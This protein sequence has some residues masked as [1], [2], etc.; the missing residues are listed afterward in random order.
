MNTEFASFTEFA[1]A[2]ENMV[3]CP[4]CSEDHCFQL[5]NSN[6][7]DL[8]DENPNNRCKARTLLDIECAEGRQLDIN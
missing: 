3:L 6:F 5:T 1:S 4:N 2:D 7:K 8:V